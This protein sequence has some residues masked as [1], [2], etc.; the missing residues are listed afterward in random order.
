MFEIDLTDKGTVYRF[1]DAGTDFTRITIRTAA[2][3]KTFGDL[4]KET[5]TSFGCGLVLGTPDDMRNHLP[6]VRAAGPLILIVVS[7]ASAMAQ[8]TAWL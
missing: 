2:G 1:N 4:L 7:N 5:N 3:A 8:Q 6:P